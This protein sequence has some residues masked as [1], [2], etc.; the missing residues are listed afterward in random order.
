MNEPTRVQQGI[1]EACDTAYA[2]GRYDGHNDGFSD[3]KAA[4]YDEGFAAGRAAAQADL[5]TAREA[6]RFYGESMNYYH[7]P[8]GTCEDRDTMIESDAGRIARAALAKL[9]ARR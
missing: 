2:N 1:A 4:G 9:E 8:S 6:L 3:G 5:D 7:G